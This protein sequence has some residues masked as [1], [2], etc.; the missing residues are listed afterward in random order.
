M[1]DLRDND[2]LPTE[3]QIRQARKEKSQKARER[4]KK[5]KGFKPFKATKVPSAPYQPAIPVQLPEVISVVETSQNIVVAEPVEEQDGLF[6]GFVMTLQQTDVGY[7]QKT[8]GAL[9][10]VALH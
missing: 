8:A 1:S 5:A 4:G 7:G 3:S 9:R 6:I 10:R 2:Y